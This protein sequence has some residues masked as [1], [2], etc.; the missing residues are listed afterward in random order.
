MPEARAVQSLNGPEVRDMFSAATA[1]LDRN[2]E[3]VN[4]INVFPVPDGDTGTNMYLTMRATMDEAQRC[5]DQTAGG[6]LA[7]MSHGALM[8]ARGN[9]GVILSQILRGVAR[10]L[11]GADVLD[12]A[13]LASAFAEGSAAA[14]KAVTKP[15]EGTV[16]TVIRE[17]SE[18]ASPNG[19]LLVAMESAVD[20]AAASVEN[21]PNLL[22]VLKEAGVVDAGAKGLYV[23]LEGM[24]KHL[25]G[26]EMEEPVAAST[27]VGHSWL[28]DVEQRHA[29][30]ASPYGYCAEV[31]IEGRGLDVDSLRETV[32]SLGDS[33]IV[34]G[35]E[36][37]VRIHVHTDDPGAILSK[38]TSVGQLAQVKI[39]NINRQAERFVQMHHETD[40]ASLIPV[41]ASVMSTVA[42]APGEGLAEVFR[43]TGC[44]QIVSGGPTMNPSTRDILDAINACGSDQVVVLPNDKNIILAAEQAV[45]MTGKQ[46]R[47]VKSRSVPQGL[48][49]LLAANPEE[50][51]EENA[52]A[53]EE[54]LSRIRTIEIT[55]AARSTTIGGVKVEAGQ[56]IAI[57][58][59]EL[60]LAAESPDDAAVEALKG[61]AGGDGTSLVTLYYGAD[62][63]QGQAD[64]LAGRLR[65]AIT[66]HE[67][68]VVYGGQPH[69]QYIISLE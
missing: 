38:G 11:D 2:K 5:E 24:L 21:T 29:A 23:L 35:D 15:T 32:L 56:V 60:K 3:A 49:A 66:G 33:V 53:M 17:V 50:G 10:A 47:V 34:V 28:T 44:E 46:A 43:S 22:P 37:L 65:E 12:S 26:D 19:D 40:V 6:M 30:E 64:A 59:D 62:T 55:L 16:L 18:A 61:L 27:A 36:Q 41:A 63:T 7:A 9:S 4:A 31:L 58:D 45:G 54:A 25:R 13:G 48:A 14:Y 57:V 39:D 42:V 20:T 69:Y 8:G 51:L 52:P 67:V 68:E 1:W